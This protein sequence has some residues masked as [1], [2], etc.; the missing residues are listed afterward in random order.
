MQHAFESNGKFIRKPSFKQAMDR[1]HDIVRKVDKR[2]ENARHSLH[3]AY[4][5]EHSS[6]RN[7]RRYRTGK[8]PQERRRGSAMGMGAGTWVEQI[9]GRDIWVETEVTRA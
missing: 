2:G 4:A 8:R 3:Y 5:T 9:Y 6:D 7:W 1:Y